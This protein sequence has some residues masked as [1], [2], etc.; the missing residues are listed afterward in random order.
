MRNAIEIISTGFG[1]LI[2]WLEEEIRIRDL[3][4]LEITYGL[5]WTKYKPGGGEVRIWN[6]QG[7]NLQNFQ[8]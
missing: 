4:R 1:I 6:F 3:K 5:F 7:I 8:G 2:K